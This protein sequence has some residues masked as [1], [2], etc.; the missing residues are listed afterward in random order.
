[1]STF[2]KN[3][4]HNNIYLHKKGLKVNFTFCPER[5]AEDKA[6]GEL[7]SL[8]QIVSGFN[9][10]AITEVSSLFR[11]LTDEI[12]V[13]DSTGAGLAKLLTN[14]WN[15][16]LPTSAIWLL[17]STAWITSVFITP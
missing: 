16:P 12:I 9:K 7:K 15:L 8:P 11:Y 14:T 4:Q 2:N 3:R 1:M 10:K 13:L 17:T 6:L 5:I